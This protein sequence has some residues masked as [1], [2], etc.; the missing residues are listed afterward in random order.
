ML[1][2]WIERKEQLKGTGK[3][4]WS[5]AK[6]RY[7]TSDLKAQPINNYLR[8][9]TNVI[10]VEGI[11]WEESKARSE[12]ERFKIRTEIATKKRNAFTWN[13]IID[14]TIDDVWA[15]YGMCQKKLKEAYSFYLKNK[16]IPEWWSFHPAYAMGNTRLSCAICVLGNKNDVLNGI[17]H[18]PDIA[19]EMEKLEVESG[20]SFKQGFSI[21]Q[22]KQIL[23]Q[24]L[25]IF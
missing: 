9:F 21:T 17:R 19:D 3:P 24:N 12:K 16:I 6:A 14:Y 23:K 20:F 18:N 5:S 25:T 22:G 2:R 13:A 7:C 11:R 1:D 4:F 10:S 8:Q 15:T